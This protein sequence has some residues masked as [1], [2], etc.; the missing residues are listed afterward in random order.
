M[1]WDKI[2]PA[3]QMERAVGVEAITSS[4][5]RI[6]KPMFARFLQ[7]SAPKMTPHTPKLSIFPAIFA[8]KSGHL[9]ASN[10]QRTILKNSSKRR[11]SIYNLSI[12]KKCRKCQLKMAISVLSRI[13]IYASPFRN[14]AFLKN[15]Y[16]AFVIIIR[17]NTATRQKIARISNHSQPAQVRFSVYNIL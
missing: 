5:G 3:V 14:Y 2:I 10:S 1:V 16:N 11:S 4:L 8:E 12:L 7:N 6:K 17:H 9:K 15:T 13:L